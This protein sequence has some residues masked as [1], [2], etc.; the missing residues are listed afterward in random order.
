[1][2]KAVL[3]DLDGTLIN[4]NRLIIE[5]YKYTIMKHLNKSIKDEDIVIYFGEPLL[6]TLARFDKDNV[7]ALCD[8]YRSFN[9]SR[10]DEM[11]TEFEGA[12]ETLK[13]LKA[14]GIKIAVVTSKRRLMVERGLKKFGLFEYLDAVITPEDTERHK[15]DGEPALKACEVLG[16][17]PEE[18]VMVGDSHYDILCGKNA[19]TKTCAVKYTALP[20]EELLS[21][22]PDYVVDNILDLIPIVSSEDSKDAI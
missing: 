19:G 11:V 20:L 16:V 13:E 3:F 10:H 8:T 18:A 5:S 14:M 7:D 12:L 4:T 17:R 1:M 15:P 21:Y 9:H 2:I 6:T 22:K